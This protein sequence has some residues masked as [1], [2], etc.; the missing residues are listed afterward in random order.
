MLQ[1]RSAL[2]LWRRNVHLGLRLL[3]HPAE[4]L[5]CGLWRHDVT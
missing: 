1:A 3:L 2:Q 4:L 5:F